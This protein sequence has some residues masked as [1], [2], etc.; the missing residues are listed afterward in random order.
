MSIKSEV[1]EYLK[2]CQQ[3]KGL[4]D[5]TLRAYR[6]DLDQ[7]TLFLGP[8]ELHSIDEDTIGEFQRFLHQRG[9]SAA[10]IKRKLAVLRA[11]FRRF[12]RRGEL[13]SNPFHKVDT[14]I[15]MPKRLPRDIQA[16][17][18][19]LLLKET[20]RELS[21]L[22]SDDKQWHSSRLTSALAIET[23]L[24][25]GMR[26]GEIV[27]LRIGDI[28]QDCA[29]IKIYGKGARERF[30]FVTDEKLRGLISKYCEKRRIE[31]STMSDHLLVKTGGGVISSQFLRRQI[32]DFAKR[33][34]LS[35]RVTP[36]MLRH[37]A[38]SQLVEAGVDIRFIQRL[39][40]HQS[41]S[42]T[43]IYTHVRDTALYS[44]IKGAGV[45]ARLIDQ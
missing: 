33:S 29:R 30:A 39:L 31:L 6:S 17:D 40:G 8:T 24:A 32:T 44:S 13:E 23:M 19:K 43:E 37:S 22:D 15:R 2:W 16:Q 4:S 26:I 45:R 25:T 10:S 21:V 11:M 7:F 38:A 28:D 27:R 18:L 3:Q 1:T 9:L 42:T 20:Q 41:I 12:E 14:N 5:D 36:H 35:T 34:G